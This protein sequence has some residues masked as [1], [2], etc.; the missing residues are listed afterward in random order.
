[1]FGHLIFIYEKRTTGGQ[2]NTDW[3]FCVWIIYF[4]F[5]SSLLTVQRSME[6]SSYSYKYIGQKSLIRKK[7]SEWRV[8]AYILIL[9]LC[10]V[11]FYIYNTYI[12][13]IMFNRYSTPHLLAHIGYLPV[14]K[15]HFIII[16]YDCTNSPLHLFIIINLYDYWHNWNLLPL[17]SNIKYVVI[18]CVCPV[19]IFTLCLKW[20]IHQRFCFY[21][22]CSFRLCLLWIEIEWYPQPHVG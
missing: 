16:Y 9:S 19:F 8:C 7:S 20:N 14:T 6:L 3:F 17:N 18:V 12:M 15:C 11:V 13:H 22:C 2:F 4:L 1:M 21:C 10:P 5:L